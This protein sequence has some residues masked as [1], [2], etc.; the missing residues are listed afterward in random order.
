MGLLKNALCVVQLSASD[1]L[2]QQ[3]A[4][5]NISRIVSYPEV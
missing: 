4:K 2:G 1:A 3:K 5:F